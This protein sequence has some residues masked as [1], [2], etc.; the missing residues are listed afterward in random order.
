MKIIA[1]IPARLKSK[2]LHEKNIRKV[3]GKPMILWV[4][5]AALESKYIGNDNLYVSTE[6]SKIKDVVRDYCYV[7][8]RP[9]ELAEDHIWTQPV[10]DHAISVVAPDMKDDDIIIILQANS[11]GVTRGVIDMCIEKLINEELWQV[12]TVSS[13]KAINNGAVHVMRKKVCGHKG[14]VNYNGV[15]VIDLVDVHTEDDLTFLE[16]RG[17]PL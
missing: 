16:I 17:E 4:I 8:D 2:R 15:V 11:P 12:H 14:K 9:P 13:D 1:V 3:W 6:S 7:I 10:I 5:K